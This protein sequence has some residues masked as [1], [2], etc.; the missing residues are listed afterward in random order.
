M[1]HSPSLSG[2]EFYSYMLN[3]HSID[4]EY[5]LQK[6]RTN[7]LRISDLAITY[8]SICDLVEKVEGAALETNIDK[9]LKGIKVSLYLEGKLLHQTLFRPK[10]LE[11]TV[12]DFKEYF[13]NEYRIIREKVK[14]KEGRY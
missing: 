2:E 8:K 14:W 6:L 3:D 9:T 5:L 13:A 7:T 11:S 10:Q 12:K 1:E 4:T